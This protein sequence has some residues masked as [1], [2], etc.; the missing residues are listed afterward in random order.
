MGL[1][2]EGVNMVICARNEAGLRKTAQEIETTQGA[3]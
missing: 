3:G 1:A 2:K